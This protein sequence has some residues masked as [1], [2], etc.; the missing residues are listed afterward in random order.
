MTD[1]ALDIVGTTWY[2]ATPSLHGISPTCAYK[3]AL[4]PLAP[5]LALVTTWP[6]STGTDVLVDILMLASSNRLVFTYSSCFGQ[7]AM[8]VQ[9]G[10]DFCAPVHAVDNFHHTMGLSFHLF[11]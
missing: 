8:H 7:M 11:R 1:M 3:G 5:R 6:F 2:P 4:M 10:R 9:L